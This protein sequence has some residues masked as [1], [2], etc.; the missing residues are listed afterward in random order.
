V[1]TPAIG[2]M[3]TKRISDRFR[4][5]LFCAAFVVG[6]ASAYWA[7]AEEA[8][9]R[10]K[11]LAKSYTLTLQ[12]LHWKTNF[13]LRVSEL[14]IAIILMMTFLVWTA[15]ALAALAERRRRR[16]DA[17][18]QKLTEEIA[19]RQR[20]QDEV[21]QLNADLERR[22][23]TRTR[24][25]QTSN[26]E[27]EAFCYSVSH[28]LRAPLRAID[29]F[30]DILLRDYRDKVDEAGQRSLQRV[31]S[32]AQ[33]MAQ[34]ID[35]L[36]SLSRVTRTQ[37]KRQDVDLSTAARE[38]AD[39]LRRLDPD[40]EVEVIIPDGLTAQGDPRLLRQ[41]LENLIGNAWKYTSKQPAARIE[42]GTCSGPT[43]N[44]AY[45]VKDNGAGFDMKYAGKLFAV[46][47]R[48]H[49]NSEFPGNGVGLAT[50]QRIILRHGGEVW[51]EGAVGQGAT[52]YFS[53][54]E[55]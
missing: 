4:S 5:G 30:S 54:Q 29:G 20:A 18:N 52:L 10:S 38:V 47:Q 43:G 26:R 9:L 34:L 39:E 2:N 17:A 49:S 3:Q 11:V 36:L 22:V 41:V 7:G 32:G 6:V 48:L 12:L 27:L 37:M 15:I 23:E 40:R 33:R 8:E 50:V 53:F 51:A 55:G 25:L 24:E 28:D 42:M 31:R 21:S 1:N 16:V 46:F 35:D 13:Q 44:L 14:G 45:F 19:E